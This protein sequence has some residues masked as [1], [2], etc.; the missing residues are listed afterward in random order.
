MEKMSLDIGECVP[1]RNKCNLYNDPL[2]D[3]T[4]TE[5]KKELDKI[6]NEFRRNIQWKNRR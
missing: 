3:R 1:R 2:K 5:D 6:K 4:D